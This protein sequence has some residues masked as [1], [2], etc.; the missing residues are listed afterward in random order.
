MTQK[1]VNVGLIGFGFSGKYIHSQLIMANNTLNLK[2]VCDQ[3]ASVEGDHPFILTRDPDAI[4]NDPEIELVVI[5]TPNL[6]HFP[7]A[8]AAL[9]ANKHVVVDKPFTVTLHEAETLAALARQQGK[10]ICA[11]QNRRWDS[12]FLTVRKLLEEKTLGQVTYFESNYTFYQPTVR[13]GW[14]EKNQAG[15]GVWFDLGAHLIDQMLQLFGEPQKGCVNFAMQRE[16]AHSPDFFHAIFIYPTLR[17]VLQGNLLSAASPARFHIN[18]TTGSFVK[19]GQ[20]PQEDALIAHQD[21]NGENWGKDNNEG[22]ITSVSNDQPEMHAYPSE[23]G[24]YPEFYRQLAN[25]IRGQGEA[26]VKI[27]E[28][29]SSM[30]IIEQTPRLD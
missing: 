17:V 10:I 5:S 19:Y 23:R 29:L 11:F 25:A 21:P 28:V 6:T 24:N 26:P 4:F 3:Q 30:R 8:Q 20:D 12:D 9:L 16:N 22:I 14:R 18:G 2:V 7:L 15:A 27:A 13:D 1:I